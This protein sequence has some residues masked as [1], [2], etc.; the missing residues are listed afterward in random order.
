MDEIFVTEKPLPVKVKKEVS[1]LERADACQFPE[2]DPELHS[3]LGF[4]KG[5]EPS[6][7]L[8]LDVVEA[9][10]DQSH[11][12]S[13]SNGS[14]HGFFSVHRDTKGVEAFS[15]KPLKPGQDILIA[16]PRSID[17]SDD[18]L[19]RSIHEADVA[20][21]LVKVSPIV[22]KVSVLGIVPRFLGRLLKPVIFNLLKLEGAVARKLGKL[23][24]RVA[25]LNPKP[26]PMLLTKLFILGPSP[27][28]GL[29]ALKA[30]KALLL[31]FS[32]T[33][34]FYPERLTCGTMLFLASL[35]PC[36]LNRF[37]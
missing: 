30:S 31:L 26:K 21:I 2:E 8:S 5:P 15:L 22:E 27:D 12:P 11:G 28:E 1:L 13:E 18:L 36:L 33:I 25:F 29:E 7:A 9:A 37:N 32:F 17:V 23:A 16:F 24:D 34:A 10:L 6:Q 19:T 14:H 4:G 35:A 20:A 3:R